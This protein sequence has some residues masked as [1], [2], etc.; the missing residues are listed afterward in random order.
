MLCIYIHSRTVSCCWDWA[1]GFECTGI[2]FTRF[3]GK[4]SP[5]RKTEKLERVFPPEFSENWIWLRSAH[6]WNLLVGFY[7]TIIFL[8]CNRHRSFQTFQ[9]FHGQLKKLS[10]A[11]Q[12]QMSEQ[13]FSDN[14]GVNRPY[15]V[16]APGH[17]FTFLILFAV[18]LY[19]C[20]CGNAMNQ[21]EKVI[22]MKHN[23]IFMPCYFIVLAVLLVSQQTKLDHADTSIIIWKQ[24]LCTSVYKVLLLNAEPGP[25]Q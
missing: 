20:S 9:T 4:W 19:Q 11:V 14:I 24:G 2:L 17:E 13:F 8:R 23:V 3:S 22:W 5:L 18:M 7:D 21:T 6:R 12:E 15:S 16:P 25:K 10:Q 1:S